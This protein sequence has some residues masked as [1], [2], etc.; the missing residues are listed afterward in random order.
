[1]IITSANMQTIKTMWSAKFKGAFA[2]AKSRYAD[3]AMVTNSNNATSAYAWLGQMPMLREWLG[4]RRVKS[5]KAFDFAIKNRDFEMTVSVPRNEVMD[6]NIGVYTSL[7]EDMGREAGTHPDRLVFGLLPNGFSQ[8]CYDGQNF[9]D[10]SH[11]IADGSGNDTVASNMQAGGLTPWYL[12]DTSRAV[13]PLIYQKRMEYTLVSKD[14][15]GDDNVFFQK[16]F[17]YGCDGR[18][19]AGYGLWQF[20]FGSKLALN[21]ANYAAAKSQMAS[22]RGDGGQ[23]L[24]VRPNICVV[25]PSLETDAKNLF[26]KANLAGGESNIYNGEVEVIVADWLAQ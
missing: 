1:M 21:T 7:I 18:S 14:N 10:N 16:E 20:A 25:P 11:P 22:L 17:I 26:S 13:R 2:G 12:L 5:L 3:V 4:D 15:P 6:D 8:P 19:N 23:L 9:F 24:G